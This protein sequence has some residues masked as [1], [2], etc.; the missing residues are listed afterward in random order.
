MGN[1]SPFID[2]LMIALN[3]TT[4]YDILPCRLDLPHHDVNKQKKRQIQ[5]SE[6][7]KTCFRINQSGGGWGGGG[8]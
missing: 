1:K 2:A 6:K 5:K 8:G 4:L 7:K 3:I